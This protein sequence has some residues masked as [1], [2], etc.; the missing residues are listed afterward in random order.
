MEYRSG[1]YAQ[2]AN[3][4]RRC[5][6]YPEYIAPRTATAHVLLAMADQKLGQTAEA[7]TELAQAAEIIGNKYKTRLDRGTPMQGFW[8]DWAFARILLKEA[9]DLIPAG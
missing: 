3:W 1:N 6:N 4:C 9:T 8:F 5:L 7:R 2:A